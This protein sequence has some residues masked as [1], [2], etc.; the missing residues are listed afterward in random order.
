MEPE[1]HLGA[2]VVI[3]S[4]APEQIAVG[5]VVSLRSGEGLKSIF[6][7][8]VTRV[9]TRPDGIW[10]ETKGD[11][12]KTLD[13]SITPAANVIGRVVVNVPY[14]GYLLKLLSVPS[15]VALILCLAGL[16]V[17]CTWLVETAEIERRRWPRPASG[18][19]CRARPVG[20]PRPPRMP[21][22]G[23]RGPCAAATSGS[24]SRYRHGRRGRPAM[25]ATVPAQG[26]VASGDCAGGSS[27]PPSRSASRPARRS[28]RCR[29]PWPPSATTA[30]STATITAATLHPPTGL[31]AVAGATVT[32]T[33]TPTVDPT[34][35]GYYVFRSTTSG[36][37]YAQIATV[38]PKTAATTTNT[39][40]ASGPLLLR[41][42]DRVPELVQPE[43]RGDL[44]PVPAARR[45]EPRPHPARVV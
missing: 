11:A 44:R 39:P 43:Q 31:G 13:A 30:T 22:V 37:G 45:H 29:R 27:R 18:P 17:T 9:L 40:A 1:I 3:E 4:V 33:W 34:A 35:A 16:L 41:A 38:T 10:I 36:S 19:G 26:A 2:A 12:N 14:G 21:G 5:D 24:G 28:P 20:Q 23:A 15:G 25:T 8:R 7:H 42:P 32:L 6:T